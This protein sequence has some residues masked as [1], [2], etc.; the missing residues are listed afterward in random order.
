M[1]D[2]TITAESTVVASENQVSTQLGDEAVIL[3]AEEGQYF[4]LN[5]VG[6]L[7]WSLVQKPVQVSRV[8]AA[9]CEQYEVEAD[10]CLEDVIA[11]LTDLRKKGLIHVRAEVGAP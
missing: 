6:A 4:G 9:V 1:S 2:V 8:S 5:D 10:Q 7:V 3:G 11:L